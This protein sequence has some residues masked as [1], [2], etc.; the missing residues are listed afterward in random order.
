M[1]GKTSNETLNTE[2]LCGMFEER[3]VISARRDGI[4]RPSLLTL[5]RRKIVTFTTDPRR[6]QKSSFETELS[7]RMTSPLYK[8]VEGMVAFNPLEDTKGEEINAFACETLPKVILIVVEPIDLIFVM[9]EKFSENSLPRL[10]GCSLPMSLS[11]ED[12]K[13]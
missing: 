11:V 12:T 3:K 9:P 13:T 6:F 10:T 7:I 8:R 1:L 4:G 5:V 2:S